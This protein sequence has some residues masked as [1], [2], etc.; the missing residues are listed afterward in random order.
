MSLRRQHPWML[1]NLGPLALLW[2]GILSLPAF[3]L[4][5]SIWVRSVQVIW[6]LVMARLAGKRLQWLYFLSLLVA[7]TVFHLLVPS[8]RVLLEA[9]P[10]I[11]TLGGLQ[12]GLFKGL[13]IVGMVFISLYSVRADLQL[14]GRF[15]RLV[16]RIF[17]AFEHIM[18]R[19][20]AIERHN[21]VAAIDRSLDALFD[22]LVALDSP[23]GVEARAVEYAT[24]KT[25]PAGFLVLG[26]SVGLQWL[27]LCLWYMEVI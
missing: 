1:A 19:R 4:Q 3:L 6:F 27:M 26:V 16:A 12:T 23:S 20:P 21:A 13:T 5:G 10:V 24:A 17:W 14:P 11:V 7:I 22:D 8:G 25:S 18:E 2:S 9:G 15:G